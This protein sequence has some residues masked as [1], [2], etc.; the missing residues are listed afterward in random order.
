[1]AVLTIGKRWIAFIA[2]ASVMLLSAMTT[3]LASYPI[4]EPYISIAKLYDIPPKILY[5]VALQESGKTINGQR[6]PWPWAMNIDKKSYWYTTKN[7]A[8]DAINEAI[9][10]GSKNIGIGTMQVTYPYNPNVLRDLFG[11]LDPHTNITLGASILRDNYIRTKSWWVAV[12]HYHSPG[13]SDERI[14]RASHYT[15]LVKKHYKEL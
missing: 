13:T 6:Y 3:A 2:I 14:Q 9:A 7:E 12:G 11:A 10:A 1:M 15:Q 4:P 5:A 8:W